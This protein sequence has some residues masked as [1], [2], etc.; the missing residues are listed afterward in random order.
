MPT[1]YRDDVLRLF[2]CTRGE[3]RHLGETDRSGYLGGQTDK[4]ERLRHDAH[5]YDTYSHCVIRCM[6]AYACVCSYGGAFLCM[7]VCVWLNDTFKRS[8]IVLSLK[9]QRNSSLR[10]AV[11]MNNRSRENSN[12][13]GRTYY[14]HICVYMYI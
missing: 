10:L 2:V 5:T 9:K 3:K 8:I 6:G 11:I 14:I 13:N 4:Q 7:A 1:L 12:S